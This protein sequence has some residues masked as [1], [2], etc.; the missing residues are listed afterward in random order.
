M[1]SVWWSLQILPPS[2]ACFCWSGQAQSRWFQTKQM[3]HKHIGQTELFFLKRKCLGFKSMITKR[4]DKVRWKEYHFLNLH[5]SI[6]HCYSTTHFLPIAKT[7]Q[8]LVNQAS[9]SI[10]PKM[11]HSPKRQLL[12]FMVLWNECRAHMV[13]LYFKDISNMY[14][15]FIRTSLDVW[16]GLIY[17]WL[18]TA[19]V[20]DA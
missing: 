16:Y 6:A 9:G 10:Q 2:H 3:R 4:I 7:P 18:Q 14:W 15:Q 19:K 20:E 17:Y 13:E 8:N 11:W 12:K 5:T 1:W